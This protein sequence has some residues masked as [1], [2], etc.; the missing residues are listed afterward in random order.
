MGGGV[1]RCIYWCYGD[2]VDN[3]NMEK[4]RTLAIITFVLVILLTGLHYACNCALTQSPWS[5]ETPSE[6]TSPPGSGSPSSWPPLPLNSSWPSSSSSTPSSPASTEKYT[7]SLSLSSSCSSLP[8][9]SSSPPSPPSSPSSET[10][11][12]TADVP[13]HLPSF[14]RPVRHRLASGSCRLSHLLRPETAPPL[15]CPLDGPRQPWPLRN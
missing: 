15:G 14:D 8:S 7:P 6:T 12:Q 10:P 3:I 5:G 4:G 13:S 11:S 1:V 2:W 9:P